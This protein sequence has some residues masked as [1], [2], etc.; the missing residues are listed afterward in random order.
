MDNRSYAYEVD[1]ETTMEIAEATGLPVEDVVVVY[2]NHNAPSGW[3][4]LQEVFTPGGLDRLASWVNQA[5]Q[6]S[7]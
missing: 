5:S 7:C 2:A 1:F 6:Q 4:V 3:E